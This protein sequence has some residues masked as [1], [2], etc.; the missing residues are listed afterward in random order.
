[1]KGKIYASVGYS[2]KSPDFTSLSKN[3]SL[4]MRLHQ[5]Q[6]QTGRCVS[7]LVYFH[8]LRD[9]QWLS[10]AYFDVDRVVIPWNKAPRISLEKTA[11]PQQGL[12]SRGTFNEC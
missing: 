8:I 4:L 10:F 2:E 5:K 1:M 9:E 11:P 12:C 3:L 7:N 6:W